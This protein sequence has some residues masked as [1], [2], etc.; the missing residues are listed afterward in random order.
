MQSHTECP[1]YRMEGAHPLRDMW[2]LSRSR[3]YCPICGCTQAGMFGMTFDQTTETVTT[4]FYPL[5]EVAVPFTGL[6]F[7]PLL[8]LWAMEQED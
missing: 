6:K 7:N 3:A 8:E 4:D 1:Y 2:P 5:S